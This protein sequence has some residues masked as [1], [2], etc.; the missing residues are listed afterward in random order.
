MEISLALKLQETCFCE[1]WN[2]GLMAKEIFSPSESWIV[3]VLNLPEKHTG[4]FFF[5]LQHQFGA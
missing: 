5:S 1:S 3:T 4:S 2:W